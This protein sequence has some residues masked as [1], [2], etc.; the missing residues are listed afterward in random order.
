MR[1]T[2][3]RALLGW[4]LLMPLGAVAAD[5][6]SDM[7]GRF[8]Q[9]MNGMQEIAAKYDDIVEPNSAFEPRG[10]DDVAQRAMTPFSS[11][12]AEMKAHEGYGDLLAMIRQHGFDSAEQWAQVGDRVMRAYAALTIAEE[13]PNMNAQLAQ[14]M[15]ELEDSDLSEEQ[16]QMM[17]GMLQSSTVVVGAVNN[18]PDADKAAVRPHI[19]AI[20]ALG[21]DP[22]N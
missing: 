9:S 6:T 3:I 8:I 7:V 15:Q 14:A 21:N 10:M 18:V 22:S 11:S 20:E 12:L 17:R 16:K 13:V 2:L 5:L 1:G 19:G 4:T